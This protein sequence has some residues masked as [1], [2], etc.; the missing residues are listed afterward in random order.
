MRLVRVCTA[1]RSP[2]LPFPHLCSLRDSLRADSSAC[3]LQR[4][5]ITAVHTEGEIE[6]EK[7]REVGMEEERRVVHLGTEEA[8][9]KVRAWRPQEATGT[10]DEISGDKWNI[11]MVRVLTAAI[12][13]CHG[14]RG[15]RRN[16]S[17]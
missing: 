2:A 8:G 1:C 12:N 14:G 5:Q 7:D 15:T 10:R 4:G 11:L 17:D 3:H 6:K 9:K 13:G 16:A